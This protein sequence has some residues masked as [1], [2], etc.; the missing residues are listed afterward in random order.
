MSKEEILRNR[1]FEKNDSSDQSNKNSNNKN[2]EKEKIT[3]K[4]VFQFVLYIAIV[5]ALTFCII[6][7]VGQRTRVSGSSMENTLSDG[8]NLI[9][10]K[11]T[12]R[13]SDIERFDIVIFPHVEPGD[14][15]K[16]FG[17]TYY[18]KRV[19][20]LPGETV[21][22]DKD[23]KIFI[24]GQL[25]EENYGREK[26]SNPGMA[27]SPILLGEDEYFLL[28]DNRNNSNDSRFTNV[29][30]IKQDEI[31]GRAW[32]RIFPFNKICSMLDK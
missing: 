13:F 25:L 19:I 21:Y 7:F 17:K 12:Y 23:G 4:D 6:T 27:A 26:I 20:G 30:P 22:I 14:E 5:F 28:G 31:L 11:I 8:D 29:G 15:D 2:T 3:K 32:V 24:N 16:L 10:D 9:V 18:I 1:S